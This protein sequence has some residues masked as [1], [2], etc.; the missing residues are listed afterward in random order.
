MLNSAKVSV[1]EIN[2]KKLY[3]AQVS[4]LREIPTAQS[5][6]NEILPDSE[7]VWKKIYSLPFQVALD[8]YTRDFQYKILNRILFSNA[9]LSKLKL[10]ESPL[11]T[12]CGKDEDTPNISLYFANPLELSGKKSLVSYVNAVLIRFLI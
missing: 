2:T 7:L 8:T 11:C 4:D 12:F 3:E 6:F 1:S 5:R 9:K 10:V